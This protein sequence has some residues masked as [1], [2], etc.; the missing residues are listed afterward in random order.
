MYRGINTTNHYKLQL[1]RQKQSRVLS[2][3]ISNELN[4]QRI[5]NVWYRIAALADVFDAMTTK[6]VYQNP[7]SVDKAI[8]YIKKQKGKHFDPELA[9]LF[10]GIKDEAL[11]IRKRIPN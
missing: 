7:V 5:G 3:S 10:I 6:R 1:T 2:Y 4:L 11:A 8:R 9:D